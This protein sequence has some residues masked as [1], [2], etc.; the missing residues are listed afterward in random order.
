[1]IHHLRR[2]AW[3]ATIVGLALAAAGCT[4]GAA[5]TSPPAP[6]PPVPVQRFGS[7][8]GIKPESIDEFKTLHATIWPEVLREFRKANIRDYSIYLAETEPG[9]FYLFS[10]FKHVGPDFKGDMTILSASP[11]MRKWW[12]LTEACQTPLSTA[13]EGDWWTHIPEVFHVD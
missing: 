13:R 2:T 11:V 7:V 10:Y 4:E 1:M 9:K 3:A 5:R 6:T 8:I 12:Q